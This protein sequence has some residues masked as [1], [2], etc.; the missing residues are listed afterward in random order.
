MAE[1]KIEQGWGDPEPWRST[2]KYHFYGTDGRSLCGRHGRFAGMPEVYDE[3]DDS[4]MNCAA[5]K[6]K[7]VKYREKQKTIMTQNK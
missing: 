1:E 5:C 2:S 6:K 7:I 3:K 4:A